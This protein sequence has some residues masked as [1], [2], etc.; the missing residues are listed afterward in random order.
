[1][2]NN[3]PKNKGIKTR[4]QMINGPRCGINK[5]YFLIFKNNKYKNFSSEIV[6][7][8]LLENNEIKRRWK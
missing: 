7:D 8:N 3:L 4:W 1:M 2:Y 5:D 6:F